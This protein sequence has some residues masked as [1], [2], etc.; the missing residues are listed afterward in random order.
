V[1]PQRQENRRTENG[2]EEAVTA[3][4]VAADAADAAVTEVITMLRPKAQQ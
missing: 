1:H 4:C 2:L 3:W